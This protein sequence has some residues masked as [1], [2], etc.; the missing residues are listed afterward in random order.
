MT[1]NQTDV[2]LHF[3]TNEADRTLR[4]RYKATLKDTRL[5][6]VLVGY[7]RAGVV[8]S[9]GRLKRIGPARGG[10]WDLK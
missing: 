8:E 4:D 10:Y 9:W 7:L 1:G 6:D 5:F 2:T 3:F